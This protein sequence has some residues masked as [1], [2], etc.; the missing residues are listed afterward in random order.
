MIDAG[1]NIGKIQPSDSIPGATMSAFTT[2]ISD[3]A[4]I[5]TLAVSD[6]AT[7]AAIKTDLVRD[8]SLAA[9]RIDVDTRGGVVSL[10]GT[11][12][13]ESDRLR[14]EQIARTNKNVVRVDNQVRTNPF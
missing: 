1:D 11:A 5:T 12:A 14:A 7:T 13:A 2:S 6:A 4:L 3:G 8:P 10:T 9:A